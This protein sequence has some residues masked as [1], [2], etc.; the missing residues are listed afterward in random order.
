M[1]SGL[2]IDYETAD[3]ITMLNL[4]DTRDYIQSE[5]DGYAEGKYLHAEDV[6][7][8]QKLIEAIAVVL[9]YYGEE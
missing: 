8:N 9:K 4:K 7:Y 5:L 2:R 1:D 6:V 3:R